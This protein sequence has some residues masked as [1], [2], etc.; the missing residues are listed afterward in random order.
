MKISNEFK[1]GV[2]AAVS[3]TVL[4]LGYNFLKGQNIFTTTNTF[5]ATY[6]N[7]DGLFRSNPVQING[8]SIG[9]VTKVDMDYDTRI[10]TVA[11]TVPQQITVPKNSILKIIN[12]DVAG[13]KGIELIIGDDSTGFALHQDTL[14]SDQDVSLLA[15]A[16]KILTPLAKQVEH[17]ISNIDTAVS[18]VSLNTTLVDLSK[19]LK[20]FQSTASRLNGM[21]D[22][23]REQIKATVLNL[24]SISRDLKS[25]SP[26]LKVI[27]ARI[28][29]TTMELQKLKLDG[30]NEK[31]S[32]TLK[33]ITTTMNT[34]NSGDGSLA[35]LLNDDQLYSQ[36][37]EASVSI[38]SL[39]KDIQRYPRRYFGFTEKSRK[40]G[41]NQKMHN[42]GVTLPLST[43]D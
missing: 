38:D 5:Y 12:T 26:D 19:T 7:V 21:I 31:V 43:E 10:I 17:L 14:T 27:L 18:G 9:S 34:V 28:D 6:E 29:S 1:I 2:L 11:V 4:V 40:K 32:E 25:A 8:H 39:A 41:D 16:A 22:E 30:I 15:G 37:K 13:S 23:S 33:S 3:I 42:E 35:K 36:L 20:A 24:N